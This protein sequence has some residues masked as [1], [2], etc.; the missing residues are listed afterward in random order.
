M[1]KIFD[2]K[3]TILTFKALEDEKPRKQTL[4]N[5]R[6]NATDESILDLGEVFND[7]APTD[8]PLERLAIVNTH[9]YDM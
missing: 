3:K 5:I 6:E 2:S 7:L 8:E 9:H 4:S 1:E